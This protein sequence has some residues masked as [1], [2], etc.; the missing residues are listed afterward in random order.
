MVFVQLGFCSHALSPTHTP[1]HKKTQMKAK[2]FCV[3]AF[4]RRHKETT[5]SVLR[6]THEGTIGEF[7]DMQIPK[8]IARGRQ[9]KNGVGYIAHLND[10]G[11]VGLSRN[12]PSIKSFTALTSLQAWMALSSKKND[13]VVRLHHGTRWRACIEIPR[14]FPTTQRWHVQPSILCDCI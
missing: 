4:P 3:L 11:R 5:L 1:A 10:A 13:S 7:F 6:C 9:A 12:N 8:S 2:F 14:L